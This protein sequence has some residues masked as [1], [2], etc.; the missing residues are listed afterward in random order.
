MRIGIAAGHSKNATD[1]Q[2]YEWGRCI[3]AVEILTEQLR[4][5]GHQ[6]IRPAAPTYERHN[7]VALRNKTDL[8]NRS[9]LDLA[10]ELHLNAGGGNYS[11]VLYWDDPVKRTH[12]PAGKRWAEAIS[13]SHDMLPWRNMGAKSKSEMGRNKLWFLDR[14]SCP[15]I[16]TEPAFKD[17]DQHRAW[18][19]SEEFPHDYA[20][21][22]THAVVKDQMAKRLAA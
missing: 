10:I 9:N 1:S 17:Y 20:S 11:C 16:I 21:M 12:S 5:A 14:T 18:M 3:L 7:D 15:A 2:V 8:F 19:D 4:L 22:I 6:V 13:A